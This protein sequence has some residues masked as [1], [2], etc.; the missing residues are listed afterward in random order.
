MPKK[1]AKRRKAR[2]PYSPDS[3]E[4]Q[5]VRVC[6]P[7]KNKN[8][9][10]MFFESKPPLSSLAKHLYSECGDHLKDSLKA[11]IRD[12]DFIEMSSLLEDKTY[13]ENEVSLKLVNENNVVKAVVEE[14]N[15]TQ[16]ISVDQWC[17]AWN[18]YTM[19]LSEFRGDCSFMCLLSEHYFNV[20]KLQRKGKRWAEYDRLFR[21]KLAMK[22]S[23]LK[24]GDKDVPL[25]LHA[26][27]T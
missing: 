8:P 5:K 1:R 9:I 11:K 18:I 17:E 21:M 24:W 26:K 14:F 27:S 3:E 25:F 16:S 4:P 12:G 19:V 7:S 6:R 22:N 2:R 15:P 23:D 10:P 20:R 13:S